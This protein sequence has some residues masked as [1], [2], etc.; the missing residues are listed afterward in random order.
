M[1]FE[2]SVVDEVRTGNCR[3]LFHPEQLISV[4]ED[5]AD[6][7]HYTV[8]KLMVDIAVGRLRKLVD[9]CSRMQGFLMFHSFGG[10]TGSGFTSHRSWNGTSLCGLR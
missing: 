9:Q 2:P 10:G 5:A 7:G 4:E 6:A 1:D 3:L 8:G